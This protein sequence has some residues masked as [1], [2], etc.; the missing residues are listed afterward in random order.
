MQTAVMN[1]LLL[2]ETA[3]LVFSFVEVGIEVVIVMDASE[4]VGGAVCVCTHWG[5]APVH[6]TGQQTVV[7]LP[8][9]S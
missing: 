9:I 5:I 1:L 3:S 4:F 7:L 8:I 2:T 6:P